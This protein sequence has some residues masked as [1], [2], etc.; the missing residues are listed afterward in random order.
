MKK[1]PTI[2]IILI[3]ATLPVWGQAPNVDED[4]RCTDLIHACVYEYE[5]T[6]ERELELQVG[7]PRGDVNC[8]DFKLWFML[9]KEDPW[10]TPYW[11]AGDDEVFSDREDAETT[12]RWVLAPEHWEY[13]GDLER[14]GFQWF[15]RGHTPRMLGKVNPA[16]VFVPKP[17]EPE[18]EEDEEEYGKGGSSCSE[19]CQIRSGVSDEWR[20]APCPP[21][22]DEAIE[23]AGHP[24]RCGEPPAVGNKP[25]RICTDTKRSEG[26]RDSVADVTVCDEEC[27]E[28][29]FSDLTREECKTRCDAYKANCKADI[30][31]IDFETVVIKTR[32]P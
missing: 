26:C 22:T 24:I 7:K 5:E 8:D 16:D 17:P 31:T 13:L 14:V 15:A 23:H 32:C 25:I 30:A 9:T 10:P 3:F 20:S 21:G 28:K 11:F 6:G 29:E 2:T 4:Y 18:P 1:F 27:Y 12:C 19:R